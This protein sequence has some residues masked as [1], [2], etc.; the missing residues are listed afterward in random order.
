MTGFTITDAIELEANEP[1][2][3]PSLAVKIKEY[4]PLIASN[5][6]FNTELPDSQ[7]NISFT[8]SL[9]TCSIEEELIGCLVDVHMRWTLG[10]DLTFF[11]VDRNMHDMIELGVGF[12]ID[13]PGTHPFRLD[14]THPVYIS[15][16]LVVLSL[17]SLFEKRGWTSRKEWMIRSLRT[18]PNASSQG[19]AFE[20]VLPLVLMECFGGKF[21]PL[22]DAFRCSEKLGSR[23]FTL[24]SLK[25]VASG[26]MQCCP[27]SW[28]AGSSDRLGLR[29][30]NPKDVLKYLDNPDG[31]AFLFPDNHMGANLLCLLQDEET[32]EL[33]LVALQSKLTPDLN[34]T[35]WRAALDSVTPELFYTMVVGIILGKSPSA[36][37]LCL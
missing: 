33:V 24:V 32:G 34:A 12:L 4:R 7:C 20:N 28:N 23:K 11:S 5:R 17:S 36:S 31:K 13:M 35:N 6:L 1:S 26:E 9:T 19:F 15:E 27:V 18:A 16:P 14:A 22:A 2:I 10:S 30:R 37:T 8:D 21:S 25:R 3:T 29:A